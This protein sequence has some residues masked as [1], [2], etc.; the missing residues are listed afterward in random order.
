V[1]YLTSILA[2]RYSQYLSNPSSVDPS[3]STPCPVVKWNLQASSILQA[4][5]LFCFAFNCQVQYPTIRSSSSSPPGSP[6]PPSVPQSPLILSTMS[7]C[8]IIYS[9]SAASGYSTF[10]VSTSSNVL[11]AYPSSDPLILAARWA[12]AVVLLCS[13]P[14]YSTAIVRDL[15]EYLYG[16]SFN[17]LPPPPSL[18]PARWSL[19]ALVVLSMSCIAYLDPPLTTITGLTGAV[20]GSALVYVLPG[21]IAWEAGWKAGGI[22]TAAGGTVMIMTTWAVLKQ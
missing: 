7:T 4:L 10:C 19:S 13:Y 3:A 5:P 6:G 11:D 8:A 2:Y 20:G 17:S 9:I 1:F 21:A 22:M 14:L 12:F 18:A 15:G 16:P